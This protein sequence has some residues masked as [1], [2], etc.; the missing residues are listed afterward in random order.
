MK[1]PEFTDTLGEFEQAVLLALLRHGDQAYGTV[2]HREL[3]ARLQ[4]VVSASA[5]YATLDRMEDKG[6]VRSSIGEPTHE[7]GGRRRRYFRLAPAGAQALS[8]AYRN[9]KQLVQG[10]ERSLEKL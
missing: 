10:L 6:Y 9:F 7:R 4:R 8:H 1:K 5:V 2:I 3:E